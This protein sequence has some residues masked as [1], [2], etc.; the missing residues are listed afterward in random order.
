MLKFL[1]LALSALGLFAQ[2]EDVFFRPAA[3]IVVR[4]VPFPISITDYGLKV[5]TLKL[6]LPSVQGPFELVLSHAL[7]N[8]HTVKTSHLL[9]QNTQDCLNSQR[10]MNCPTDEIKLSLVLERTT[11]NLNGYIVGERGVRVSSDF[12]MAWGRCLSHRTTGQYLA[13]LQIGEMLETRLYDVRSTPFPYSG[14]R[15][16]SLTVSNDGHGPNERTFELIALGEDKDGSII[17]SASQDI[18]KGLF[19]GEER[20][21]EVKESILPWQWNNLCRVRTVVNREL[22]TPEENFFNNERSFQIGDCRPKVIGA[23]PDLSLWAEFVDGELIVHVVNLSKMA[24]A[25]VVYLKLDASTDIGEQSD[26]FQ[27]SLPGGIAPLG[28]EIVYRW[29]PTSI[30]TCHFKTVVDPDNLLN[31]ENR[32]NNEVELNVCEL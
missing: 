30:K 10:Q 1:A 23:R 4:K 28:E 18:S 16:L 24:V 6:A 25:D 5:Q 3:Q 26:Q 8:G 7:A 2:A 21:I 27:V 15:K 22:F 9:G 17:W 31:E 32:F 29:R 12:E 20:E 11:C 13:D 19:A 14:K